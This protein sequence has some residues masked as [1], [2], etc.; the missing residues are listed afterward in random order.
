MGG[1]YS[2]KGGE[3]T[4]TGGNPFSVN[5]FPGFSSSTSYGIDSPIGGYGVE[6]GGS[7]GDTFFGYGQ[8]TASNSRPYIYTSLSIGKPTPS[9]KGGA[10]INGTYTFTINLD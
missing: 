10:T 5:D 7:E 9:L 4:P 3:I 6:R 8:P 2:T 1:G